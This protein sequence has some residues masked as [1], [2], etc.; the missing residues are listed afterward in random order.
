[1]ELFVLPISN[2]S[3]SWLVELSSIAFKLLFVSLQASL[4]RETEKCRRHGRE[5]IRH[6]TLPK[7]IGRPRFT[8]KGKGCRSF[9][10]KVV[11]IQVVSIQVY[12]FQVQIVPRTWLKE[13]R[14]SPKMFFLFTRKL[15][16]KWTKFLQIGSGFG[17]VG[18]GPRQEFSE[19]PPRS[20]FRS[21]LLAN[22][23]WL[24]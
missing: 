18:G 16:L 7:Q 13:R 24:F 21:T 1:M 20:K 5:W 4:Y 17:E 10:F 19:V 2:H 22:W 15:Y 3:G 9:R 8:S 12:S 23:Q 11:S 14:Y 6:D